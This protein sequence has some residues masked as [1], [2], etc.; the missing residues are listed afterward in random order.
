[1]DVPWIE[2]QIGVRLQAD[3]A[4]ALLSEAAARNVAADDLVS[5]VIVNW[6]VAGRGRNEDE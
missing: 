5:E 6:L 4:A 1:M 3:R 2:L